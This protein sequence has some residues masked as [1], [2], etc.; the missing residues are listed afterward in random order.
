MRKKPRRAS[1]RLVSGMTKSQLL[2]VV[3]LGLAVLLIS[4][5]RPRVAGMHKELGADTDIYAIPQ[6]DQLLLL[7][8]GYRAA[9]ADLLFGRTMVQA[10][11]HFSE[12]RVFHHLDAYLKGII[13]LDPKYLDVYV[14]ADTLLNLSTVVMPPENLRIARDIQERGLKEFPHD[15]QL[16][17]SVGQFIAY[18]APQRLPEN[19]DKREWRLTGARIIEHACHIWSKH[20]VLP[21]VCMSS[22]TLF[23]REGETDA[24]I[25]SLERLIAIADDE[26]VRSRAM[27]KLRRLSGERAARKVEQSTRTLDGL[28]AQDLPSVSRLR[29]QLLS[30]PF[31]VAG[32]LGPPA[33][34]QATCATSFYARSELLARQRLLATDSR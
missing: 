16:W 30:P 9:M 12:H 3:A 22:A 31:D 25:R 28:R 13:A 34:Q 33:A 6:E 4:F 5:S 24:A 32:C 21:D 19:E 26:R 7:S 10:G 1:P 27:E 23:S 11:V 2:Q 18:L 20:E 14:Y 15:P 17:L 29:Y 8:L